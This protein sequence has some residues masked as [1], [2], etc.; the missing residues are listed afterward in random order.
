MFESAELC[1]QLSMHCFPRATFKGNSEKH[2]PQYKMA[3]DL[4]CQ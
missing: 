4:T 1:G 3:V 2:F